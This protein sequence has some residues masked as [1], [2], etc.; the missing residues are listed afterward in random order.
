M[1]IFSNNHYFTYGIE[2]IYTN[3]EVIFIDLQKGINK[4]IK[5]NI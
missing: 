1:D 2:D 5:C 4:V 3:S